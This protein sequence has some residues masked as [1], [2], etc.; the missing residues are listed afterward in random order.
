M[1]E[2]SVSNTVRCGGRF[3]RTV[4]RIIVMLAR[5]RLKCAVIK[6]RASA[7]GGSFSK[8]SKI[9]LELSPQDQVIPDSTL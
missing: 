8:D 7:V 9:D 3:P 1:I 2:P 5:R 4:E 6:M